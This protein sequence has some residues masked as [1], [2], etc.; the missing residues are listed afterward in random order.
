METSL[1]RRSRWPKAVE[2]EKSEIY[3]PVFCQTLIKY[4]HSLQNSYLLSQTSRRFL[5]AAGFCLNQIVSWF[6]SVLI[7][8]SPRSLR[9]LP[10]KLRQ[11]AKNNTPRQNW[12]EK[13]AISSE[14]VL[15]W[16]NHTTSFSRKIRSVP[17]KLFTGELTTVR[18][19]I[20]NLSLLK[21]NANFVAVCIIW[22]SALVEPLGSV[23]WCK[24]Q[25]SSHES[26]NTFRFDHGY[27]TGK[28]QWGPG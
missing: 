5:L 27:F 17:T 3:I 15:L 7:L 1:F 9:S 23:I 11:P 19:N 21:F 22:V 2:P 28:L 18:W 8:Y 6:L 20:A 16:V 24:F 4:S 26:R 13:K 12:S 14:F 10:R 25:T